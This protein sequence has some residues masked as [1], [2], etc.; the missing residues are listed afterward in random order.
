M[1]VFSITP[2]ISA[3][4]GDGAASVSTRFFEVRG[5][6]R[7]DEQVVEERSLVQRDNQLVQALRRQRVPVV[8]AA[9]PS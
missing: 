3:D 9:A 1:A 7:I 8:S 4:T 6:L 5:R 2:L